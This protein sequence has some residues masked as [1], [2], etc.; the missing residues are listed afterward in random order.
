MESGGGG[1]RTHRRSAAFFLALIGLFAAPA[2]GAV[3][4]P[5]DLDRSFGESGLT[6]SAQ[7]PELTGSF[8]MAVGPNGA[9]FLLKGLRRCDIGG[10]VNDLFVTRLRPDGSVDSSYGQGGQAQTQATAP[11][12]SR[13][14]ARIAA[15]SAG[16]A[17][18][19]AHDGS[20]LIVLRLDPA[21]GLD[22][23]FSGDGRAEIAGFGTAEPAVSLAVAPDDEIVTSAGWT[24][25]GSNP[26]EPMTGLLVRRFLVDGSTDPG[27]GGSGV[28][29]ASVI[30]ANPFQSIALGQDSTVIA[31]SESCCGSLPHEPVLLRIQPDGSVDPKF[32]SRIWAP[33]LED[34]LG[35]GGRRVASIAVKALFVRRNGRLDIL[36][37]SLPRVTGL[38]GSFGPTTYLL[39]VLPNGRLDGHF[40]KRGVRRLAS[41]AE[42]AAIEGEGKIFAVSRAFDRYGQA[43]M[44]AYR[45]R[46]D[47]SL[48]RKFGG[49]RVLLSDSFGEGPGPLLAGY[50]GRRPVIF[51]EGASGC[52]SDCP[53]QPLV[54]RLRGGGSS[55]RCLG[56]RATIV[57]TR[58]GEILRGT[59]HRDVIAALE[60][61]D[62]VRGLGGRDLICGG[63]GLDSLTGGPGADRIRQ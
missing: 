51:D 52:R 40:G 25:Q 10:C 5:A 1:R 48:D 8:D 3:A 42:A 14:D 61:N 17:V 31:V 22:D 47:G 56:R 16:R 2:A 34:R 28:V 11:D 30:G 27:F 26:S 35:G 54:I 41:P 49:G 59:P 39:R 15:D 18:V 62:T 50:S 6:S 13:A 45:L 32:G 63:P 9:T 37:N 38:S 29:T 7:Q 33:S 58:R 4:A 43:A 21:G 12:M 36:V 55:A 46:A 19:V 23:T 57:G 60:G 20:D 24:V 53:P 44:V